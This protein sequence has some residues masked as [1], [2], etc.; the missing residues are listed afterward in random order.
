MNLV[1]KKTSGIEPFIDWLKIFK[2][3]ISDETIVLETDVQAGRFLTK[4]NNSHRSVVRYG[5]IAFTESGFTID[6][7]ASSPEIFQNQNFPRINIGILKILSKFIEL[8]KT[9]ATSNEFT[10]TICFDMAEESKIMEA[11]YIRLK[12]KTL[13]MNMLC[14][15]VPNNFKIISDEL[16]SNRLYVAPNPI[17]A[18]I[19]MDIVK[20]IISISDIFKHSED[21]M[22]Y[23]FFY[24]KK[25]ETG[26]RF[27]YI[28][29]HEKTYDYKIGPVTFDDDSASDTWN[30][31]I[32]PVSRNSF[33]M[34]IKDAGEIMNF[35]ISTTDTSRLLIDGNNGKI[36]TII[37]KVQINDNQGEYIDY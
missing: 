24:T 27:L 13:T 34:G 31:I 17:T 18:V 6:T 28:K 16:F 26:Q 23:M 4:G 8:L 11:K 15:S 21:Y 2:G 12:S 25:D 22:N 20:N 36:K 19:N 33:L 5:E 10:M 7:K 3:D 29:D 1:F 30:D 37:A 35:K 9:F 14:A 32:L